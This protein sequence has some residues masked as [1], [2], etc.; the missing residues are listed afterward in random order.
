MSSF[1]G[2]KLK[3]KGGVE[4]V[5]RDKKKKQKEK[6]V[7]QYGDDHHSKGDHRLPTIE[8][9]PVDNNNFNTEKPS[10]STRDTRTDA[11]KRF[12][13]RQKKLEEKRLR[14]AASLSHK[15]K[16]KAFNERLAA[17]SEHNDLFRTSY[18]A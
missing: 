14:K 18:T 10:S 13:E 12:E 1:V 8:E 16:V 2:G 7:K 5:K 11:E 9:D 6:K 3:L 4:S 15:E 17:Q